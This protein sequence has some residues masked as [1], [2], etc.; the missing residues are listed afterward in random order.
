MRSTGIKRAGRFLL[1]ALVVF[2]SSALYVDHRDIL[3][4]YLAHREQLRSINATRQQCVDLQK[5]IESSR[6]RVE[7]LGSDPTEIEA[8][9]RHTKD[10]VRQG[11]KVYRIEFSPIATAPET[12]NS[13]ES[14]AP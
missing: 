14:P 6:R 5:E 7:K 12:P 11:E 8:A 2:L 13:S 3:G 1:F 4:R 10:L 9:I